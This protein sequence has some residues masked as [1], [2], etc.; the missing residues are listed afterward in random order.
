[1]VLQNLKIEKD[2]V[3]KVFFNSSFLEN[4]KSESVIIALSINVEFPSIEDKARSEAKVFF[5]MAGGVDLDKYE[6]SLDDY[7][8]KLFYIDYSS[9]ISFD[10]IET[11]DDNIEKEIS[12]F[13]LAKFQEKTQSFISIVGL[14]EV[15]F[16]GF[17][18]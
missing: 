10:E 9:Y 11:A 7:S 6:D 5:V 16:P 15:P 13:A 12:K 14:P 18:K 4:E 3:N 8:D 2:S 1:M 17:G